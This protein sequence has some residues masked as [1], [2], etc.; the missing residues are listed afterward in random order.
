MALSNWDTLA[1]NLKG[2]PTNG[3]FAAPNG[4][5]V[6]FY[7]NHLHIHDPEGW[8]EKGGGFVKPIVAT[9]DQG[10]MTYKGIS[11]KAI[12]GPQNGIYAVVTH[13]WA[14]DN[15]FQAM[16]GCG[17]SGYGNEEEDGVDEDGYP[18]F[19]GVRPTS[20]Q[21]LQ[22]WISE[23]EFKTEAEAEADC[24]GFWEGIRTT[25][26]EG[27][28]QDEI[29][30]EEAESKVRFEA[31]LAEAIRDRM[32]NTIFPKEIA[33][34]KLEGAQRFNQGDAY[35]AEHLGATDQD[36]ATPV[37]EA[38]Q[39]IMTQIVRNEDIDGNA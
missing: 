39:T 36:V 31:H 9:I 38:Q 1:V 37:G 13:G 7:K 15:T 28:P 4:V 25:W 18:P 10:E 32:A 2:E 26:A 27:T 6:E 21:F 22:D 23:K 19:V 29:D 3:R 12:R 34:V 17:V 14:H 8:T 30:K 5:K 20:L 16:I 33:E 24:R 11:I 35:F